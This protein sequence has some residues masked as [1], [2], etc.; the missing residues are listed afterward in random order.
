MSS[1][2]GFRGRHG[3]GLEGLAAAGG[4]LPL[5]R[6]LAGMR[7]TLQATTNA[8]LVIDN[9]ARVADFNDRFVAM[10]SPPADVIDRLDDGALLDWME[11]SFADPAAFRAR[12]SAISAGASPATDVLALLDGR[13]IERHSS[14]QVMD[15]RT[16]GR[17]WS[18]VDITGRQQA[19]QH[20]SDEAEVLRWLNRT[21]LALSS[22]LEPQTVVEAAT[23]ASA[24]FS[25]ARF[26]W[27]IPHPKLDGPKLSTAF[28]SIGGF[29]PSGSIIQPDSHA[30][31]AQATL[32]WRQAFHCGDLDEDQ[33]TRTLFVRLDG[34][35]G[36]RSLLVVP[37][38]ARPDM[39]L[40]ALALEH[41]APGGF[42]E[43]V[44][45]LVAALASHAAIAIDNARLHSRVSKEST[46]H[47]LL[48]NLQKVSAD[49]L[50]NLLRRLMQAEEEERKR[51]GR[52][53]H[54]RVGANLS[55]LGMGLELLRKQLPEDRDGAI[56][57][58]MADLQDILHD[59]VAHV[60][61]VLADLRPTALDELGLLP[62]LRHQAGVL[63]ARSGI[64]FVVAG[65]E[66]S[67]RLAPE[68]EIAF[69]RIAQEAWANAMKHSGAES[70]ALAVSQEDGRVTM[71]IADDGQGFEPALLPAGTASLG[72][73]TMRERADAIGATLEVG[74]ALGTG[75][76]V[77]LSLPH[78]RPS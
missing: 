35:R 14:A 32:E 67:P 8:I 43:R 55:A 12:V 47:K 4:V 11:R 31:L 66:P 24:D 7:A 2:T 59:T 75:V 39:V 63:T 69:Y 13:A 44:Q 20:L 56:A 25:G 27:F 52:E 36:A 22:T 15:G 40:G 45:R 61:G 3:P 41:D 54:D 51:L 49:R 78:A 57:R 50:Q 5:G 64:R 21:G 72:M 48:S 17:L 42:S 71:A 60:R 73:T 65:R 23:R 38:A 77:R 68:C 70:V 74:T 58:R 62:A 28:S 37:V 76:N 33:A 46:S 18:F 1:R 19:E 16:I 29:S 53:L 10:W 6:S 34:P 26:G 30:A 9:D